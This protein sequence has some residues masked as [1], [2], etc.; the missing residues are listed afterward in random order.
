MTNI[1][2]IDVDGTLVSHKNGEQY[3]PPSALCAMR[4]VR[5][6]GD[7]CYLCTGRSLAE[8]RSIGEVPIDGIIGAAGGFVLDGKTMVSHRRL[9]AS[10]VCAIEQ[11]LR[12]HDFAYY[13]ESN[14]G[15]YFDEGYLA[16]AQKAWGIQDNSSFAAIS[17][18]VVEADRSDI[19]KISFRSERD[20]PFALVREAFGDRFY[21]VES[22]FDKPGICAG[23]ISLLG[24]NKATA[25]DELLAHLNLSEVR[26]FGFGDSQ[27]DIEMLDRCDVAVVMGDARHAETLAHATFVTKPVL[28]DGLA[29]ALRHFGLID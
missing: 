23:E 18:A 2:F 15:L 8:A 21:L 27:N 22:S 24:V 20:V 13:L 25:I 1:L 4:E 9:S 3:I 12:E 29:Y 14:R 10:D 7:R 5:A 28:E 19:N 11:W 17:H 16:Y 26:T 6:R